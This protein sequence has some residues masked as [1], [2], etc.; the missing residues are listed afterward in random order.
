MTSCWCK[1]I[2]CSKWIKII[3]INHWTFSTCI[4]TQYG[5]VQLHVNVINKMFVL[6]SCLHE[7]LKKKIVLKK[8]LDNSL[9]HCNI[10]NSLLFLATGS[11]PWNWDQVSAGVER[12]KLCVLGI[13]VWERKVCWGSGGWVP[14]ASAGL[15]QYRWACQ[16]WRVLSSKNSAFISILF[17]QIRIIKDFR[18]H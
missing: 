8:A 1:I 9:L 4:S 11:P 12:A 7:T 3:R 6:P 17:L 15:L 10:I 13:Y 5:H 16:V 18:F 14:E 2:A